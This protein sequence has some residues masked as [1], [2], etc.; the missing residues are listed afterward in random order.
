MRKAYLRKLATSCYIDSRLDEKKV[1]QVASL[2]THKDLK[3]FV[4]LV[5]REEMKKTVIVT[6]AQKLATPLQKEIEQM[7]TGKTIQFQTDANLLTG[8]KIQNADMIYEQS[9]KNSL[10]HIEKEIATL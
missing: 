6:S 9:L 10:E 7:Y 3:Q 4:K 8:M 1:D 5:R 2:L